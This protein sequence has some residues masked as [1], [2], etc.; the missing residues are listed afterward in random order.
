MSAFLDI[1]FPENISYGS[2]GGPKFMTNVF[3]AASGAEQR[4]SIWSE[5]RAEFNVS[6]G[7]RDKTDMDELISF[8]YVV[9]GKATGFLYKD[10]SD[11][12]LTD[13]V[14]GTG[15]GTQTV[16]QAL[17]TYTVGSNTHSRTIKKLK[18]GSVTGVKVD[19]NTKIL[20]VDYTIDHATGRITFVVPPPATH[21]VAITGAEFY[22]PARFDTDDMPISLDAFEIESWSSIPVV[23]LR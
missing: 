14:I 19:G 20:T 10:W 9:K 13:Q 16:F 1:V 11:Y 6:H 4:N 7:I 22:I 15:T 8:F 23:E 3:T 12:Q 21:V 17:K 2:K 18:T 5:A